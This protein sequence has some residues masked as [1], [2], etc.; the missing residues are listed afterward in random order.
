MKI[1]LETITIRELIAGF[2]DLDAEDRGVVG[3]GGRLNIRP[4]YQREF[5][6]SPAQSLKVIDTVMKGFPLNVMYWVV[7]SD[8]THPD[9]PEYDKYEVLDGQQRTLSI[10]QFFKR[11]FAYNGKRHDIDGSVDPDSHNRFLNYPLTVYFCKGTNDE[12]KSWFETINTS[13]EKLTAQELRNAIYVGPWLADA[14]RYFSKINCTAKQLGSKYLK[15]SP[16]NQAYLE[17][18]LKWISNRDIE[19]YRGEH[20]NDGDASEL[21]A[22][23]EKVIKWVKSIFPSYRDEMLGVDWGLL[24]NEFSDRTYDPV[25]LELELSRL[26]QDPSVSNSSG[27][28]EY[29]LNAPGNERLTAEKLLNVRN[30]DKRIKSATYEAQAGRCLGAHCTGNG[31]RFNLNEMQA[32]HVVPWRSGGK[33]VASNCRM[34]CVACNQYKGGALVSLVAAAPS[35]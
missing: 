18:V 25:A 35:V 8:P 15:G 11:E 29:V 4:P 2:A 24:Y 5:V 6:Y 7:T 33:T 9:E 14:K 27:A 16:E 20:M 12:K 23:F 3:Y 31:R 1:S 13:G 34:L 28:F 22:Y 21:K 19:N 10:C 30:F 32:D 17:T 26:L